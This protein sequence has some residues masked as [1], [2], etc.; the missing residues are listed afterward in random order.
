MLDQ[1]CSWKD[2]FDLKHESSVRKEGQP[3]TNENI[4]ARRSSKQVPRDLRRPI[5]IPDTKSGFIRTTLGLFCYL[6]DVG[7][8]GSR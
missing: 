7:C 6:S 3:E 2:N 4:V 8:P 5:H 1:S